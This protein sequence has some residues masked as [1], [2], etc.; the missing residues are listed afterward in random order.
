VWQP[1]GDTWGYDMGSYVWTERR[2]MP[3]TVYGHTCVVLTVDNQETMLV[4]GG[5]FG[6]NVTQGDVLAFI[7]ASGIWLT[8]E[9]FP[10]RVKNLLPE[11]RFSHIAIPF[12]GKMLIHGGIN[13]EN[14]VLDDTWLFDPSTNSW[15]ELNS[16]GPIRSGHMGFF[17]VGGAAYFTG[18][19][20]SPV[21]APTFSHLY[22]CGV[23]RSSFRLDYTP[24][25]GTNAWSWTKLLLEQ[26]PDV[27]DASIMVTSPQSSLGY[28]AVVYGGATIEQMSDKI[29]VFSN[30]TETWEILNPRMEAI[31]VRSATAR[32]TAV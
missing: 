22:P 6:N 19:C 11:A 26:Y 8:L 7:P 17:F 29:W 32:H 20:D 23:R 18:G 21:Q 30:G 2:R 14:V 25:N 16:D 31:G 4:Y 13:D 15:S 28:A 24:E 3:V 12:N 27:A 1:Q 9:S 10:D 5:T